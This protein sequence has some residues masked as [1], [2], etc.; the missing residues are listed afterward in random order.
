MAW[1]LY[2]VRCSDLSLYAG[3]ST[4]VQRRVQEHNGSV[5]GAKYTRGRRPVSL[6]YSKQCASK[7]EALREELKFKKLPKKK[8]E[9][10]IKSQKE[11][12]NGE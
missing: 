5:R 8:K 2:V 4:D 9:S 6:A 12:W 3:V 1:A 11:A 10:I 7:E